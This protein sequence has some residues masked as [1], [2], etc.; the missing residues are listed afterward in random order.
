MSN[1][2]RVTVI[3]GGLAGCEAAWQAA[4]QGVAVDLYEMKP[5]HFSPAHE[6]AQLGELVCSNS[7][8]SNAVDSAA[9][10]LKEEMRQLGSL[11]M[12]A[13]EATAVPAG[14]ALAVDRLQFAAY[15]TAAIERH[16]LI[17]VHRREVTRIPDAV[18]GPVVLAA[19]PLMSA[20][21]AEHLQTLTGSGNLA[22]YDAIAPI[23][24]AESLNM[25][26][27]YRKSRWDDDS[28]GD[29]L[30]CPMDREQ[31]DRFIA[32]LGAAKTVALHS[33]EDARYFEGCLPIEVMCERGPETLRFGPMK[34]IG[35]MHPQTGKVPY[36]VVQLRAE[37][38]EGT[39]YNLVGFQTKLTYPEQQRIFRT[40]PGLEQ[41]VFVRLG[42]IHRN[43]F[44]CAPLVLEPTLQM[45]G[46]PGL[47]LAG[48]VSGVEGYIESA[49]MGLLAGINAGRQVHGQ[50]AMTPP[51]ATAHG[52]LIHHL[53]GSDPAHFQPSN[54]NFGLFPPLIG[55]TFKK[56]RGR[57]RAELALGLIKE[58]QQ[59]LVG[60]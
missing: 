25:E 14:K 17:T 7:L 20:P 47:Y 4:Q 58:W 40:I 38:Q 3:G 39:M 34:P 52:A 11:F 19:G 44:V 37:N 42:S 2:G 26:V 51:V 48:Q 41:A 49:A 9:G 18:A 53:T 56:E 36:A 60:P 6:L 50:A 21:L 12:R 30:N 15:L 28:P 54:V 46:R 57:I 59:Q 22:F 31:Y 13:A 16:P 35:L 8:R 27:L 33:F 43:T 23:V 55:R 1:T 45:K 24:D 32:L 10:L 5:E 29:Y